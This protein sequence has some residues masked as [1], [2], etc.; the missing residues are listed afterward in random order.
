MRHEDARKVTIAAD[1]LHCLLIEA[2][3]ILAESASEPCNE[4]GCSVRKEYMDARLAI[5]G[6]IEKMRILRDQSRNL[7]AYL[8]PS[9]GGR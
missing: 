5:I 8:E 1:A 2:E 4:F 3:R 9:T 7:G 6:A